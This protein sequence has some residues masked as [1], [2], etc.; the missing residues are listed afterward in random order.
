MTPCLHQRGVK[1]FVT[2]TARFSEGR[3][4]GFPNL[5]E[6]ELR[7]LEKE[8]GLG[9]FCCG[10]GDRLRDPMHRPSRNSPK[11]PWKCPEEKGEAVN[12]Y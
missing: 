11:R 12:I 4:A 5:S 10:N 2:Y 3:K 1:S 7:E 8:M 9:V 6:N